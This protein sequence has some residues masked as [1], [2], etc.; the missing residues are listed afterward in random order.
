MTLDFEDCTLSGPAITAPF[1]RNGFS[2]MIG[3]LDDVESAWDEVRTSL[4]TGG[5]QRVHQHVTSKLASAFGYR[6]PLHQ[7]P[8]TTR[9]GQEDGGWLLQAPGG[10]R[11]RA[12][13]ISSDIDLDGPERSV[14]AYRS[15]PTRIAQRVLLARNEHIGLMTNG[16]VVRLLLCDPSRSDSHLSVGVCGW[17]QSIRSPDSFRLLKVLIGANE[18]S[19]LP[20]VLDAARLHQVRVTTQ[21]RRQ[22]KEAIVGFINALPNRD[23]LDPTALW[24]EG[25]VLVYRLLFILKLESPAEVGEGFS[26]ASTRLWRQAFSPNRALAPLVRRHLDQGHDTGLMLQNGLRRLFS[27]F[28]DGLQC[29]E[30]NIAPLGG[31]L[32]GAETTPLLDRLDWGERAVSI[33]LDRL[34]WIASARGE[35]VRVHYGSLDVEDLGSIYE[36]L[37]EQEP[38]LATEPL[39][40]IGYGKIEAVIPARDRISDI[41]PGEFF[42]RSGTGR[43]ASGSFYTPNEFVRFLVREALDPKIAALSPPD[44]PH[45]ARL[46]TLKIVDPATGS[47]H[48][49]VE[50][51]RYL[52]EALLA[53]C[54]LCDERGLH[55]RIAAV[56]DPDHDDYGLSSKPWLFRSPCASHL[57]Q[58]GGSALPV[59]LRPEQT[60]GGTGKA[61]AVAGILCRGSAAD[62]SGSPADPWRRA[63]R[64]FLYGVGHIAG[65]GQR[66]RSFAGKRR[67]CQA[68]CQSARSPGYW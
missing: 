35:R 26:F 55:D 53:A 57:P 16:E 5:A 48:F 6:R 36:G 66:A 50:A 14:R 44:D 17:R 27:I 64:T 68:G 33:L 15:S 18:I 51:C 12:W 39:C 22:A 41:L 4:R 2:Q 28:R 13:S 20:A 46:L 30:L 9:E 52:G 62:L 25:L 24:H 10:G 59:W 11:L 7:D 8:V 42:L 63:D 49:L 29:S 45:P 19:R 58:A 65:V 67:R 34:I 54:R 40:R 3:L 21:L 1:L 38:G 56:P 60:G 32:F 31:A 47:G 43:K 23:G 37:L 61:V